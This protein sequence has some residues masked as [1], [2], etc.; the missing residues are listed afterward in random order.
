M[1]TLSANDAE[2]GPSIELRNA[3][4]AF[5]GAAALNALDLVCKPGEF[6]SI[7]GTSGCGKSTMLR[8][9]A[10]LQGLTS[11]A[12]NVQGPLDGLASVNQIGFVFQSPTLLPWR[13]ALENVALP[14]ELNGVNVQTRR[15]AARM[16]LSMVGLGPVDEDKLPRKLSGGM[17]MRVSLARTLVTQPRIMLLDEPLAAVDDI[18]RN[19][20][21]VE[22]A[23]LW[24]KNRWT[25]ILVTHN[26]AE[27]VFVSQRVM[28]MSPRPGR[29]VDSVNVS[30]PY[31]RTADLRSTPRFAELTGLVS[32]SLRVAAS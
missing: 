7:V 31:P 12:K 27:A 8:V 14:L 4:V 6:V 18:M 11:G 28:V 15:T 17:Q 10:G 3:R 32:Q 29:I 2:C 1:S 19:E 26:V 24:Q 25:T 23:S 5:D 9:I 13:S 21:L 20:L 30:L 16:A 22:L